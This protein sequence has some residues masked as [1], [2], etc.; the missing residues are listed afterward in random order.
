MIL[1]MGI[2]KTTKNGMYGEEICSSHHCLND[3]HV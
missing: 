1:K 2:D 3:N